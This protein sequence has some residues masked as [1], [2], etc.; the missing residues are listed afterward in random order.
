MNV[1]GN[2]SGLNA[3]IHESTST[4]NLRV[5]VRGS[6]NRLIIGEDC[7]IPA[8]HI[9]L[10]DGAQLQIG[11]NFTCTGRFITHQ[12][13]GSEVFIGDNCLFSQEVVFRPSDAHK[14]IDIETGKR[15]NFPEPI[16]I[17]N[18]VWVGQNAMFLKG[19]AI[20]PGS[21]V[22]AGAVVTKAFRTPNALI[23]GV[24]AKIVRRKVRW[25]A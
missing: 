5:I 11:S 22:A 18:N 4:K 9:F 17:D 24:P 12:H 7:R 8:A 13:E 3:S 21:I 15:L 16:R 20:G 6:G 25:E 10:A 19:S 23:A 14:I 1:E 2:A